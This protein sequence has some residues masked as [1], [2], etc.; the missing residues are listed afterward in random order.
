MNF[1]SSLVMRKGLMFSERKN[2]TPVLRYSS[3]IGPT[4]PT[5][6]SSAT[7]SK[8]T[9][10][11]SSSADILELLQRFPQSCG[12][13]IRL[14]KILTKFLGELRKP[15]LERLVVAAIVV[16]ANVTARGECVVE[17]ANLVESGHGTEAGH[18]VGRVF[19]FELP[20]NGRH[21]LNFLGGKLL[22]FAR[23]W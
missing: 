19:S 5:V 20:V 11:Q 14:G 22:L 4:Y 18:G 16:R 9:S 8:R 2:G 7:S 6:I 10:G 21:T 17:L 1:K 23:T 3:V 15:F 13:F 12:E